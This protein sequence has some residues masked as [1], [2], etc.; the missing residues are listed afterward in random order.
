M[1]PVA[2]AQREQAAQKLLLDT[3]HFFM[4]RLPGFADTCDGETEVLK[5]R[6]GVETLEEAIAE[7]FDRETWTLQD[8]LTLSSAS[9]LLAVSMYARDRLDPKGA[10]SHDGQAPAPQHEPPGSAHGAPNRS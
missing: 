4:T 6:E 8:F 2:K 7:V 1:K 3:S 5:S 9:F 10:P